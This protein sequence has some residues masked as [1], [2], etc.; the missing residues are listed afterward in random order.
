M[1]II[2]PA[3]PIDTW[4]ISQRRRADEVVLAT[5]ALKPGTEEQ[6]LSQFV[7]DRW[8]LSPAIF[9]ENAPRSIMA[10]DFTTLD[11]P[12]QRL[13]AKEFIWAR[14]NEPSPYPRQIRMAATMARAT[15]ST[16]SRFM[17][18][19][20][21]HAGMF[22]MRLVDQALLDAYLAELK[23]EP[24]RTAERV[25]H[26]IDIP[27]MLDR[28]GQFLT[29]GS[30]SF[31]P[32][33]GRPAVRIAGLAPQSMH[34]ENRTRRIPEP[35]MGAMLRWS[36]KYIDLFAEDIF[37]ARAE[38]DRLQQT[39]DARDDAQNSMPLS[40][41]LDIYIG[42]RC[43]EGRGIP[44][45]ITGSQGR[46]SPDDPGINFHIIGLQIGCNGHLL[47][48]RAPLRRRLEH[49]LAR[50]DG[51]VGGMDASVS[52][53]P[54]TSVPWRE[55]FDERSIV[56]EERM[57]QAAAYIVC[58]YLTGMRDS[59]LQAMRVGCLS[60]SPSADGLI[61]RHRIRSTAYK[62][63]DTVGEEAE[64]VTIPRVS[65]AIEVAARLSVRQREARGTD[66]I[67]QTLATTTGHERELRGGVIDLLNDLREQLDL[68][69]PS[70][71]AIPHV[72]GMP[73]WFTPRQFRRTLAWHIANR[74]FGA[75]A[76]KIQY[77]HASIA[78]FEGYSGAS[79]SGFRLEVEQ[80]RALGQLDDVV[81][82][83]EDAVRHGLPQAGPA[84]IR[85][86]REFEHIRDELGELPGRIVDSQR[87]RSMLKH[88]GRTLHVGLL[89]DCFFDPDTALCLDRE[90][91]SIERSAPALSHCRPDRCPNACITRRHLA[92][93][94]ASIAEGDRILADRELS[95][96]QREALLQDNERKRRL[97]APLLEGTT[98]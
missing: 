94:Q 25:A 63:R 68:R 61:E 29:L 28:Y 64:W 66:T 93:W 73:W 81:V 27:V 79:P 74:P 7:D 46:H 35:V 47:A 70:G 39:R 86:R 48:Y 10:I 38:L 15:L 19:V 22:V 14:L 51:E 53:D 71:P 41:R 1:S 12:W 76:G 54:D 77:K 45:R 13:T 26:L 32:W 88:L 96:F 55:G 75:V 85:L 58:A 60:V 3:T 2:Q 67:W 52:I 11:D 84:A 44:M 42:R 20:A 43:V 65:Q 59:E 40:D 9:R 98:D 87:L 62:S 95:P 37:A 36:L 92:P 31:R 89:A 18:F 24:G 97:I 83:Y 56:Q 23:R 4:A 57:L 21:G 17:A 30:F 50:L 80:E 69:S 90:E 34:A 33:R 72:D 8:D 78:M 91:A 6:H 49:A 5:H 16:L 82:Y